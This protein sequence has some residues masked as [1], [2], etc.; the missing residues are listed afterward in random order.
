MLLPR[1]TFLSSSRNCTHFAH[2]PLPA[3]ASPALWDSSPVPD[4]C[5]PLRWEQT[6]QWVGER[7][8]IQECLRVEK[9]GE[10]EVE[11]H[12]LRSCHQ[13]RRERRRHRDHCLLLFLP[14]SPPSSKIPSPFHSPQNLPAPYPC[15][16]SRTGSTE[17]EISTLSHLPSRKLPSVSSPNPPSLLLVS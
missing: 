8:N 6:A 3:A 1:A 10:L 17:G 11:P 14:K 16:T 9:K 13:E 7:Q 5:L 2:S 12:T 4:L 15:P